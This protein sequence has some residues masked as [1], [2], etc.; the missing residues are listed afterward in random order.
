MSRKF[1]T[2][3]PE[4]GRSNYPARLSARGHSKAPQMPT[5]DH[6]R[7]VQNARIRRQGHPFPTWTELT[8][9]A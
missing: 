9:A 8:E 7:E 3:H 4:R 1:N 2:K 6:L 5:L